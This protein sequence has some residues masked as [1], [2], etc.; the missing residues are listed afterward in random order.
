MSYYPCLMYYNVF[1]L[2]KLALVTIKTN[3][4]LII[5][6]YIDNSIITIRMRDLNTKKYQ[7]NLTFKRKRYTIILSDQQVSNKFGIYQNRE[8]V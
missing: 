8:L 3:F 5:Y 7:L 1:V 2:Q 6:I 4:F